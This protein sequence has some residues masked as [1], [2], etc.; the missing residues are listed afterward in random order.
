MDFNGNC[1]KNKN[2][3]VYME[4]SKQGILKKMKSQKLHL[5]LIPFNKI[6]EILIGANLLWLNRLKKILS[7]VRQGT[8]QVVFFITEK[9]KSLIF[10]W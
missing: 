1:N 8:Y 6:E 10:I 9:R 5:Q 4:K 2:Q 7:I 3:D